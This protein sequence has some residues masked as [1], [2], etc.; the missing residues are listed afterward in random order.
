MVLAGYQPELR[1]LTVM[2]CHLG[3]WKL[4][5]MRAPFWR[6]YRNREEGAAV[7]L[8]GRE[9]PITAGRL[10]A[11]PPETPC[12]A[13]LHAPVHHTYLHFV[14]RPPFARLPRR[15]YVWD[16]PS[17]LAAQVD[18]LVARL[19]RADERDVRVAMLAHLLATWALCR[20]P[21]DDLALDRQDPRIDRALAAIED[22]ESGGL[23]NTDLARLAG[24]HPAAFARRFR[25]V[26]GT[27]PQ[28]MALSRRI[29][30]AANHLVH[31]DGDID[32]V[33]AATG[34]CDRAHFSRAF[35]KLRGVAPG[36][37]RD[38]MWADRGRPRRAR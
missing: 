33:A 21:L 19:E 15:I 31:G 35:K 36:A 30:R 38:L 8:D 6:L 20:I 34:F 7:V 3:R 37:F 26:T 29:E 16:P 18:E 14:A 1:I 28:G 12:A 4:D 13:R 23:T 25:Q 9:L 11:I 10:V 24:M 32:A 22:D 17:E 2:A 5:D 27:T